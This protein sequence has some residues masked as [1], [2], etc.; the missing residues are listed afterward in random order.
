M[1]Q[2]AAVAFVYRDRNESYAKSVT[3]GLESLLGKTELARAQF[4]KV[5]II[6]Y[7]NSDELSERLGKYTQLRGLVLDSSF[8]LDYSSSIHNL[9]IS[10]QDL[11]IPTLRFS[12]SY[13]IGD[14]QERILFKTM[15]NAFVKEVLEYRPRKLR[16]QERRPFYARVKLETDGSRVVTANLSSG[17]CFIVLTD[18]RYKIGEKIKLSFEGYPEPVAAEACWLTG[19]EG[20]QSRIPGIGLRFVSESA[21]FRTYLTELLVTSTPV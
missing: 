17:G 1:T 20:P 2:E 16:S 14:F 3:L 13:I 21:A 15:W 4:P 19:W 8:F 12:H 5:D 7:T 11:G 10:F 9:I 18:P 6:R